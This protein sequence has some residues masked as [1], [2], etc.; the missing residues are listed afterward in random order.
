MKARRLYVSLNSRLDRVIKK[1]KKKIWIFLW[2]LG[3]NLTRL[4]EVEIES[5]WKILARAADTVHSNWMCM[6]QCWR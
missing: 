3:P 2:R 5:I 6:V 4:E 1:K